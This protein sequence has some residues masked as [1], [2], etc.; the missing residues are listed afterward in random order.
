MSFPEA[1]KN[2]IPLELIWEV[3]VDGLGRSGLKLKSILDV[4][5][6]S[7]SGTL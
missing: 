6:K 2:Y 5:I 1:A 3:R 4:K 7:Q